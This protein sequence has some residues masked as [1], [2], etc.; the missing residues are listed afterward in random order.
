MNTN[1]ETY[2][3]VVS[4]KDFACELSEHFD[5]YSGVPDSVLT[6]VMASVSPYFPASRENHALSMAFGATLMGRRP[7]LMIQNSG[8]GLLI[9]AMLGLH[10]LYNIGF[11]MIISNRGELEWEEPQHKRWGAIT[12][13]LLELLDIRVFD[14]QEHNIKSIQM[15]SEY[16][17]DENRI[18]AIIV[19]RGNLDE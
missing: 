4:S 16:A 15:A 18:S 11:A 3:F 19:H 9:D 2:P 17:Y 6:H 1:R 8:L 7:C 13:K 5:W 14:F 12:I 10:Q